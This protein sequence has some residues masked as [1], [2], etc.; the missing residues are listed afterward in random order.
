[1]RR[2]ARS[3][4]AG[5]SLLLAVIVVAACGG[6]PAAAP[7]ASAGAASAPADSAPGAGG[8]ASAPTA[9][10]GRDAYPAPDDPEVKIKA[11]WCAVAGAMFPLWAAK[12][13]GIFQRHRIDAELVFMQGGSPCVA[14]MTNGE[15]D[16]LE[17]AGGLIAAL[18]ASNDGAVIANLYLGNPYRLI[19]TP[20]ITRVEDLRGRRLAISRPGEWDNRLNEVMLERHGLRPNEDVTLVPIG[21]QTDR[22][23]ALKTGVVD[24]TTVNP[25]VNLAAKNEGFREIFNLN[26]L[27]FSGVYISLYTGRKTLEQR[28][29]LVERF[30]AAIVEASA[31][32]RANKEF[33]INL[34]R[35]YL[36]LDDREALEG[37]YQAYA[38]EMLA[39]PPRIPLDAVQSVID[40]TLTVSPNVPV[41]EAAQIVDERPLQAVEASGFVDAVLA[42]YPAPHN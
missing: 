8:S 23:N 29:R 26:D 22:Y 21:G 24:G 15:V 20:D 40:E 11:A 2:R 10:K 37:A 39:I 28:P 25:P 35:K 30:L 18:M 34:M 42:A 1:M 14:A 16:F 41:R 19:V 17:S 13:A 36:Q 12:D 9:L 6:P 7:A 5:T 4:A 33:T 32:A 31:Y 3:G 27:N 38:A